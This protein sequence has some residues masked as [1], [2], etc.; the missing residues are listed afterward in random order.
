MI[1]PDT[2]AGGGQGIAGMD[3]AEFNSD[4]PQ[5]LLKDGQQAMSLGHYQ[6]EAWPY[7]GAASPY[8]L[9]LGIGPNSKFWKFFGTC[10]WGSPES[11]ALCAQCED[12]FKCAFV[13]RR[14]MANETDM[15]YAQFQ[16]A[17]NAV[18]QQTGSPQ[19]QLSNPRAYNEFD[20]NGLSSTDLFGVFRTAVGAGARAPVI[21]T[22]D[23]CKLL[24]NVNKQR[25]A[26]PI[27]AYD[28]DAN[29]ASLHL[30]SY[31]NCGSLDAVE[32]ATINI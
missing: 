8:G 6:K 27:Y 1:S 23:V 13:D 19:C 28:A 16:T 2:W 17:K 14:V 4:P 32:D 22:S 7:G 24:K 26:W 29:G 10:K 31:V 9:L 12:G 15:T 20:T 25:N 11:P 21:P 5:T 3:R 18:V 30:E